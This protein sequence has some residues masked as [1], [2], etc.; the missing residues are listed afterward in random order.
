MTISECS[1]SVK[2]VK[3]YHA[4]EKTYE[5]TLDH[6]LVGDDLEVPSFGVTYCFTLHATFRTKI[7]KL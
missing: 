2:T 3:L 1:E 7:C 6:S 4:K 5:N